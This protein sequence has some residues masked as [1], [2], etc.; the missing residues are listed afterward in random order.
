MNR[1]G[2]QLISVQGDW[3]FVTATQ[4][5]TQ[6]SDQIVYNVECTM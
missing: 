1:T 2:S 5:Y 4:V 6:Q 3:Y